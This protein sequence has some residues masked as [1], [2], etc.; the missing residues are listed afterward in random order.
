MRHTLDRE[1]E[2]TSVGLLTGL[3]ALEARAWERFHARDRP[4]ILAIAR[5]KGLDLHEADDVAQ[6]TL[7]AIMGALHAGGFD[8]A[9]G[10]LRSLVLTI[11]TRKIFDALRRRRVRSAGPLPELAGREAAPGAEMAEESAERLRE[12]LAE[13]AENLAPRTL[14]AFLMHVVASEPAEQVAKQLSTS[15][16]SVYLARRR[17]IEKLRGAWPIRKQ[18]P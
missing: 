17:V 16:N 2:P 12:A 14:S 9:R 15:L 5:N 1:F 8:P 13:A 4:A 11:A 7:M 18:F 10:R 6:E 3:S